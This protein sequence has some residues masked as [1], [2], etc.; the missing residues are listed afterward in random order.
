MR[1]ARG[2][3]GGLREWLRAKV[4]SWGRLRGTLEI[5]RAATG[6]EL[7]VDAFLAHLKRRYLG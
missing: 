6:A 1:S 4:H 2:D 7:G 3:F 5:L